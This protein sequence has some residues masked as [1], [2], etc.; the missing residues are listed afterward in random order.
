MK[1]HDKIYYN[2][3]YRK[4]I[5][6]LSKFNIFIKDRIGKKDIIQEIRIK[7]KKQLLGP[8]LYKN[9]FNFY[10]L[11]KNVYNKWIHKIDHDIKLS[12]NFFLYKN[13]LKKKYIFFKNQLILEYFFNGIIYFLLILNWLWIN[14]WNK[15]ASFTD[16]LE[17]NFLNIITIFKYIKNYFFDFF[18]FMF[19]GY[20]KLLFSFFYDLNYINNVVNI[21]NIYLFN[22]LNNFFIIYNV[23]KIKLEH[24]RSITAK[25]KWKNIREVS[26]DYLNLDLL[27]DYYNISFFSFI[28]YECFLIY[29]KYKY[30]YITLSFFEYWVHCIIEYNNN[31]YIHLNKEF[32]FNLKN[33]KNLDI[34]IF[35]KNFYAIRVKYNLF[36]SNIDY[37]LFIK[38]FT[39]NF[40]IRNCSYFFEFA[41][42][43]KLFLIYNNPAAINKGFLN[44]FNYDK[45]YKK[46]LLFPPNN[47]NN[48]FN[49]Y[50]IKRFEPFFNFYNNK[51]NNKE[52][53]I[54]L[55]LKNLN[56]K[57][58]Y[59]LNKSDHFFFSIN[60]F[61]NFN[62]IDFYNYKNRLESYKDV[63]A[64][65]SA[66]EYRFANSSFKTIDEFILTIFK[67][68][69]ENFIY[70]DDLYKNLN[71]SIVLNIFQNFEKNYFFKDFFNIKNRY[72]WTKYLHFLRFFSRL[73]KLRIY[74]FK[75]NF[76]WDLIE[77][78]KRENLLRID[79]FSRF[80]SI[81][82]N[83]RLFY[84]VDKLKRKKLLNQW[85]IK[86]FFHIIKHN[87]MFYLDVYSM[88]I[89]FSGWLYEL[90]FFF[91]FMFFVN[92]YNKF[93]QNLK[94]HKNFK[95]ITSFKDFYFQLAYE[96]KDFSLIFLF[97]FIKKIKNNKNY[98]YINNK[99]KINNNYI[100]RNYT[101][102]SWLEYDY[103][104]DLFD[105]L[106]MFKKE[107]YS[108]KLSKWILRYFY[109]KSELYMFY[110]ESLNNKYVNKKRLYI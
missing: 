98:D 93:L 31:L 100:Y 107:N 76:L 16:I 15:W 29:D 43:R 103:Y 108:F 102:Y 42:Q 62:L 47:I 91:R 74:F 70:F 61:F 79:V 41:S 38:D 57:F 49:L 101:L 21:Y 35:K 99:N 77:Y 5:K 28:L 64:I 36:L 8:L 54:A 3:E 71:Y 78:E 37:F 7:K 30:N 4:K 11:I 48:D 55:F 34:K 60:K 92:I 67:T 45:L 97:L 72:I 81:F 109:K 14:E 110:S 23:E 32:K 20:N 90:I 69:L 51:Y 10:I 84:L 82:E 27:N 59:K 94:F 66:Y 83:K 50:N 87:T 58:L 89:L 24:E 65:K 85:S 22:D 26:F 44:L 56:I 2:T 95:Y 18:H 68:P 1:Q 53:I 96:N 52:S 12:L 39:Y 75:F 13:L 88:F 17:Y 9:L 19:K 6:A 86:K 104:N 33:L 63:M 80:Y 73:F 40:Y 106:K 46:F 105:D 25:E